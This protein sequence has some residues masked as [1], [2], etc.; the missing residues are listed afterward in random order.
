MDATRQ[1]AARP[2]AAGRTAARHPSAR[3]GATA[4]PNADPALS[5]RR[6]ERTG[7]AFDA[8]KPDEFDSVRLGDAG[9]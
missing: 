9:R 3:V 8:A 7:P 5:R 6:G 1:Q 2:E 4:H